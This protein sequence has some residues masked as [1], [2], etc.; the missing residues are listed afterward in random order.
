LVEDV[1]SHPLDNTASPTRYDALRMA[2]SLCSALSDIA[3]PD[4]V[5]HIV[6]RGAEPAGSISASGWAA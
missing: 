2:I 4:F 6:E 5:L 1:P 3:L